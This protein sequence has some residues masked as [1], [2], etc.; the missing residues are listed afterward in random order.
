MSTT[1][2]PRTNESNKLCESVN[3]PFGI[4][5]KPLFA[6]APDRSETHTSREGVIN[7][8][9]FRILVVD[10]NRDIAHRL[11]HLIRLRGHRVQCAHTGV[12]A[13]KRAHAFQPEFVLVSTVLPDL[14]GYEVAALLPGVIN[15]AR[16]SVAS[17]ASGYCL[18]DQ[19]LSQAAGCV[20][21]LK[22][23]IRVVE[24]EALLAR[25]GTCLVSELE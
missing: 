17:F 23:P 8:R 14:S 25:C 10:D 21:H 13:L 5:A 24:V 22:K 7:A 15:S 16:L 9:S 19:Y 4:V 20:S 11:S 12:A 2:C 6:G 18:E 1:I 3:E